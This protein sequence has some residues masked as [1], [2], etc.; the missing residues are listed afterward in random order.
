[1]D[2]TKAALDWSVALLAPHIRD[3]LWRLAVFPASFGLDAPIA[4]L[5]V[6]APAGLDRLAELRDSEWIGARLLASA[7]FKLLE[8][9]RQYVLGV[10][11]AHL[12]LIGGASNGRSMLCH[13]GVD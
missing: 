2:Q 11:M 6:P 1:V 4:V 5:D 8:P 3:D 13:D 12:I 10:A 9:I 7:R